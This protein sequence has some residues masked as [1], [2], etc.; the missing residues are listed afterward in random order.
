MGEKREEEDDRR[1]KWQM[2][3]KRSLQDGLDN[4]V[5]KNKEETVI[6]DEREEE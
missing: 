6:E 2:D 3:R 1:N 4:D 5:G